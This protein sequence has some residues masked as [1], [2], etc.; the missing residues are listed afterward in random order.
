MAPHPPSHGGALGAVQQLGA[1]N[2]PTAFLG[3]GA[4]SPSFRGEGAEEADL[5]AQLVQTVA[6]F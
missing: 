2:Q 3:F 4:P 1:G 6:S 5:L